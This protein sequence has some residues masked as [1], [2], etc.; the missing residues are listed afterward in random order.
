ME[1]SY[2]ILLE[3]EVFQELSEHY[4]TLEV[5]KSLQPTDIEKY[6]G[7]VADVAATVIKRVTSNA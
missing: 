3:D 2:P 4:P 6:L 5:W 7:D 1:L